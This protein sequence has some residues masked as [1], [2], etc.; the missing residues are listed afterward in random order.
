MIEDPKVDD[1]PVNDDFLTHPPLPHKTEPLK[2]LEE[3]AQ[4][5]QL[6]VSFN[7]SD[8]WNQF[9][10]W[11]KASVE[12]VI[13]KMANSAITTAIKAAIPSW[14]GWLIGG[15]VLIAIIII[16]AKLL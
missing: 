13:S 10:G 6:N 12:P 1:M 4:P 14:I 5:P 16:L 3:V 7:L 2:P 15:G 9:V 8:R 11:F